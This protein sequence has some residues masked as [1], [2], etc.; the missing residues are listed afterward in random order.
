MNRTA[1][2]N[3]RGALAAAMLAA[4][5]APATSQ[6]AEPA[7]PANAN[8]GTLTCTLAPSD[9]D[10]RLTAN[11]ELSCHFDAIAGTD[12][13]FKGVV[14]RLGTDEE[15]DAKI[16]LVWSVLAPTTDV[17]ME[18]LEGRYIGSL[19]GQG[20]ELLPDNTG[21]IGGRDNNIHLKPLTRNPDVPGGWGVSVLELQRAAIKA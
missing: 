3:R 15:R 17:G 19:E 18:A 21:L 7:K 20:S 10:P 1:L 6:E 9:A 11:S 5:L 4:S 13:D 8:A 12:A 16:V 2:M 14:K